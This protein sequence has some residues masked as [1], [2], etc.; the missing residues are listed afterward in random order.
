MKGCVIISLVIANWEALDQN[1]RGKSM[2]YN[3]GNEGKDNNLFRNME[4]YSMSLWD[5]FERKLCL[6]VTQSGISDFVEELQCF[7][8]Q[9]NT[10][11]EEYLS[12]TQNDR[13]TSVIMAIESFLLSLQDLSGSI[14]QEELEVINALVPE[15][16]LFLYPTK[17]SPQ[18]KC[19]PLIE[20]EHEI[21]SDRHSSAEAVELLTCSNKCTKCKVIFSRKRHLQQHRCPQDWSRAQWV[22]LKINGKKKFVC[23]FKDCPTG[24]YAPEGLRQVWSKTSKVWMHFEACHATDKDRIHK[25]PE[26]NCGESF[27]SKTVLSEHKSRMHPQHLSC[28]YCGR[29]FT[30]AKNLKSHEFRHTG[31]KP[32]RCLQC[33]YACVNKSMLNSHTKTHSKEVKAKQIRS[34]EYICDTCGQVFKTTIKLLEHYKVSHNKEISLPKSFL[35]GQC[36]KSIQTLSGFRRHLMNIHS[37]KHSCHLCTKSYS[38]ISWLNIHKRDV[39]GVQI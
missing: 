24:L 32:F 3:C 35:C 22:T 31:E 33:D 7:V 23:A 13:K 27:A 20:N 16:L 26:R 12:W 2:K 38:S 37:L 6:K 30:C 4:I 39:H 34:R 19:E 18:I 25:C 36:G 10:V 8:K 15:R 17:K 29:A 28:R 21:K 1:K 5:F 9:V 11:L 14:P